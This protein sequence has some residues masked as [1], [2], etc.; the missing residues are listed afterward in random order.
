MVAVAVR[1]R[2][3][4]LVDVADSETEAVSEAENDLVTDAVGVT[5]E[6]RVG[7]GAM[8][9]SE[10]HSKLPAGHSVVPAA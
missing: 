6:E 1:V 7:V 9:V 2:L 10:K 8:P 5:D 4:L 3:A